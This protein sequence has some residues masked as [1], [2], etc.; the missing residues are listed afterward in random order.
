MILRND[1][2]F[3][4]DAVLPSGRRV[5]ILGRID[6]KLDDEI[7]EV[8]NRMRH[9]FDRVPLYERIQVQLYLWLTDA[10]TCKFVQCLDGEQREETLRPDPAF[11]RDT[12]FPEVDSSL[13]V[14]ERVMRGDEEEQA[15]LLTERLPEKY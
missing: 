15:A 1:E 3:R 14:L 13:D 11:L 10:A 6:G 8:K 2:L 7:V 12:V 5:T 9:F 4:K